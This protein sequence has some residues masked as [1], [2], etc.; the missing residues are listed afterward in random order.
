MPALTPSPQYRSP[1]VITLLAW[2]WVAAVLVAYLW[3]FR[4]LLASILDILS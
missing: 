2:V 3:Q 4:P 1:H